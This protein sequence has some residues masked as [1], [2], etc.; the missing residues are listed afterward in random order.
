MIKNN[1]YTKNLFKINITLL[2]IILIF[3][4]SCS[5][6]NSLWSKSYQDRIW[7]FVTTKDGK[8][9]AFIGEHYHYVF[10]DNNESIKDLLFWKY[11]KI[12]YFDVSQSYLKVDKNNN[13]NGYI[14]IKTLFLNPSQ[15]DEQYLKS[16]GFQRQKNGYLTLKIALIGKRYL[17][18]NRKYKTKHLNR[19]YDFTIHYDPNINFFNRIAKATLSPITMVIEAISGTH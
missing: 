18:D 9:V 8:Q 16:L 13:L 19:R 15:N 7:Q 11:H 5:F 10:P 14:T 17:A 4:S 6:N 12:L 3:A 1:Q 2:L